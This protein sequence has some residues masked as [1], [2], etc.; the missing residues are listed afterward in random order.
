MPKRKLKTWSRK[1]ETNILKAYNRATESEREQ[2]MYWYSTAHKD[3]KAIA[4]RHGVMVSAVAGVIAALSPGLQWGLNLL[5]AD[6]LAAA[7][8]QD[9][10]R[11][12]VGVYGWKNVNK[13]WEILQG[14]HPLAVL[15]ET[16]PKT[17]AF[18]RCVADPEASYAVTVDRHAKCLAHWRLTDRD[19]FSAVRVAEYAYLAWHYRVIAERLGIMPHQLQAI[20]WVTWKRIVVEEGE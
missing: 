10:P 14:R 3:A 8:A 13:A 17:R 6:A 11:P 19:A 9:T 20:T 1:F 4:D 2:G 15:P 12:N 5:Q 18:Y 7:F 16:G